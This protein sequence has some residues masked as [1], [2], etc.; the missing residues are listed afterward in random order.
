MTNKQK[1]AYQAAIDRDT[2]IDSPVPLCRVCGKPS[3]HVHHIL[4]RSHGGKHEADNL[5]CLCEEHHRAAHRENEKEY[6]AY[7][8]GLIE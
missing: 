3:V 6:R 5:I 7:L 8:K 2:P 1:K 4:F